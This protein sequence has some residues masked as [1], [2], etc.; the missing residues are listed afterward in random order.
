MENTP[1]RTTNQVEL[2]V[3][4]A[5]LGRILLMEVAQKQQSRCFVTMLMLGFIPSSAVA[6]PIRIH[7]IG[8]FAFYTALAGGAVLTLGLEEAFCALSLKRIAGLHLQ[9]SPTYWRR[10]DARCA[11]R[12]PRSRL[13]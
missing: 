1:G 6:P 10:A 12:V 3:V 2:I 11:H 8:P 9:Q 4:K 7:I 13:G 5:L